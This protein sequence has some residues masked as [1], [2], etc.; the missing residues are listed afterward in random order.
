LKNTISLNAVLRVIAHHQGFGPL[1]Q[2]A[3][4]AMF[5]GASINALV[6]TAEIVVG[7][8]PSVILL[9]RN[10]ITVIDATNEEIGGQVFDL[11]DMVADPV[12]TKDTVE[13]LTTEYYVLCVS[14]SSDPSPKYVYRN[15][16]PDSWRLA[17]SEDIKHCMLPSYEMA[18]TLK[19][20]YLN[21]AKMFGM[22][23][24]PFLCIEQVVLRAV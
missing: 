1:R 19:T 22:D 14:E 21:V 8:R 20:D 23:P 10:Q 2:S 6:S 24:S 7:S 15:G 5:P 16:T 9:D 17:V 12:A 11:R 3:K 18:E 4:R 13:H